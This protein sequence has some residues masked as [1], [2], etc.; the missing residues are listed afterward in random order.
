MMFSVADNNEVFSKASSYFMEK[1]M[2]TECL[3]E[4]MMLCLVKGC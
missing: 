2:N 1:L 3:E 4:I